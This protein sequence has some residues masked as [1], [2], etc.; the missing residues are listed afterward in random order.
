MIQSM[1]QTATRSVRFCAQPLLPRLRFHSKATALNAM[2]DSVSQP[3][4]RADTPSSRTSTPRIGT[5]KPKKEV[6]ILMLHGYTQSGPL[7]RAKTRA[8]EKLLAKI[9]APSGI[10]PVTVY[11][12]APNKL[13]PK[14]IPGYEARRPPSAQEGGAAAES[15]AAADD[16]DIDAWAWFRKDEA[17]GKFRFLQEGME[18]VADAVREAG[19]VDAV[20]GF[21]QGGCVAGMVAAAL[22]EGRDPGDEGKEHEGWWRKLREANGGR[23][24]TFA[25]SYSGF[26]A[27]PRDL[28][29]LYEPKIRTPTLHYIGSLDTVVEEARSQALVARCEEAV[30]LTHPGGHYVP[31]TKEWVMPLA[32][33]VKKCVE[34]KADG[35]REGEVKL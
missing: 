16:Q 22:E 3:P 9:L 10:L 8:L 11:P 34:A 28:Q 1:L 21:S 24:L 20:V 5:P 15:A 4:S 32:V 2:G 31:I 19:G 27:V 12:T 30:V 13:S 6:R 14:D 25:V 29:W 23:A 35:E 17:S 33:F 18:R 26:Q 7:F